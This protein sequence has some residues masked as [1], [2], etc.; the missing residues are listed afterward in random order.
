MDK[1]NVRLFYKLVASH[2]SCVHLE[3]TNQNTLLHHAV[4]KLNKLAIVVLLEHESNPWKENKDS[5]NSL[6]MYEH[7]TKLS[8][9]EQRENC[10]ELLKIISFYDGTFVNT[11][12]A[13]LQWSVLNDAAFWN[14]IPMATFLLNQP[15][16]VVKLEKDSYKLKEEI[17]KLLKT[18]K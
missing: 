2:P 11:V 6:H 8:R 3:D 9:D 7:I 13:K 12:G 5:Q 18:K 1:E 4:K 15:G 17:K 16:I 10:L 14:E